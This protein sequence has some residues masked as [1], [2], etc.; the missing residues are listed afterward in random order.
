MSKNLN[1]SALRRDPRHERIL[2]NRLHPLHTQTVAALQ[3]EQRGPSGLLRKYP[4]A[5]GFIGPN[6]IKRIDR[7]D[8]NGSVPATPQRSKAGIEEI[9]R[10][11]VLVADPQFYIAVVP[12]LPGGYLSAH[13]KDVLGQA[14]ALVSQIGAQRGQAGAV[15]VIAFGELN[16]TDLDTAGV[17]RLLH[18]T[19]VA[20][21]GYNPE[22]RVAALCEV[23]AH[24][25]PQHWLLPD[26]IHGGF[27]TGCRLAT[28]L[29]ERP[30]TQVWKAD[31][32]QV[33]SRFSTGR[34][35]C[36][37]SIPHILMLTEECYLPVD[38]TRH[39]V[40]PLSRPLTLPLTP[41]NSEELST[42][43]LTTTRITDLGQIAV[44]PNAIPLSEAPFIISGGN[45]ISD[46]DLFH[47]AAKALSATEGA[48]RV[49]VD[50]GFMPRDRQ[51]G[52]SGTW[53]TADMYLAV[54]ISGAI[55]HMQGIGECR[56]VIAIN[57]DANCD[58]VKRADL[59]LIIDSQTLLNALLDVL[60]NT[61]ATTA[62]E[63]NTHV[64]A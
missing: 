20:F 41:A 48:S 39:A 35:D 32:Q 19:D 7:L 31:H 34:Q 38:E 18:L 53:V 43:L 36:Q 26:S 49:A 22:Q 44:D 29:G 6:G 2:R 45:G 9:Q 51:V 40:L 56:K 28:T 52:A 25:A 30:A 24:Y 27:D 62:T 55:Q 37:R 50:D 1:M 15:I 58:M 14:Q 42:R 13:D 46:W 60:S 3:P 47:A 63:D 16:A 54:G 10:P 61:P 57:T 33:T 4:H 23:E 64:A 21:T 5:V 12:D 11:L 8:G 17:D 59:S